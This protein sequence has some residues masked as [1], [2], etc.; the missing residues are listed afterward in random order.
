MITWVVYMSTLITGGCGYLGLALME[1]LSRK[2][3]NVLAYDLSIPR[4]SDLRN[5]YDL[6]FTRIKFIKGDILEFHR[7]LEV[8]K[9]FNVKNIVHTATVLTLESEENPPRAFRIN[10]EGTLN[11]LEAARLMDVEKVVFTSSE[12]VY[13]VTENVLIDEDYPKKPISIYGVTKLA[14]EYLGLKYS[15]LYGLDFIALRIPM[16]YG[17]GLSY[18]GTRPINYIIESAIKGEP[19]VLKFS[20]EMKVEPLHVLD[21]VQAVESSLKTRKP[22]SKVYNIGISKMYGL[23]EICDIVKEHLPSTQCV[24]G[25]DPGTMIYPARGPLS[26][27]RAREELGYQPIYLPENGIP[28]TI[29]K[30]MKRKHQ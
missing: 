6:D 30:Y 10:V 7:L 20:G 26:I 8:V 24:F 17:F 18:T 15:E 2:E 11:V 22:R 25:D 23:R 19:A 4:L 28:E 29:E 16:M 27:R 9:R 3:F 13:G 21:A 14:S 5:Y 12:A 1:K